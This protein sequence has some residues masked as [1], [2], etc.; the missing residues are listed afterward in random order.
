[1]T[2]LKALKASVAQ[3]GETVYTECQREPL[4]NQAHIKYPVKFA[5]THM[6]KGQLE[7]GSLGIKLDALFHKHKHIISTVVVAASCFWDASQQLWNV[8][9]CRGEYGCRNITL[10]PGG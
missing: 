5:Q 4:L 10:N 2:M 6:G 1:M 9:I 3:M 8:L 7:Q